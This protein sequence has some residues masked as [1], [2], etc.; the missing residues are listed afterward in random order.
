LLPVAA[1]VVVSWREI[2]SRG[3]RYCLAAGDAVSRREKLSL[4][5]GEA[6]S[7]REFQLPPRAGN[8]LREQ[9]APGRDPREQFRLNEAVNF[10]D[11][12]SSCGESQ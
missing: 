9:V 6:D 4:A 3:G 1:G 10:I 11:A 5:A 8:S 12:M 2:L 7:R